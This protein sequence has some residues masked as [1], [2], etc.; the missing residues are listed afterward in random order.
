MHAELR[1][2][3]DKLGRLEKKLRIALK[4]G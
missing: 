1:R 3:S 4:E 2:Q